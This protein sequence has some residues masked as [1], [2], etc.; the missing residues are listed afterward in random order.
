MHQDTKK[1]SLSNDDIITNMISE[2]KIEKTLFQNVDDIFSDTEG[3]SEVGLDCIDPQLL[4]KVPDGLDV[5][6]TEQDDDTNASLAKDNV[7]TLTQKFNSAGNRTGF[8]DEDRQMSP[9]VSELFNWSQLWDDPLKLSVVQLNKSDK[10]QDESELSEIED[11]V[12][13]SISRDDSL[14]LEMD[15]IRSS[16]YKILSINSRGDQVFPDSF[17]ISFSSGLDMDSPNELE[18]EEDDREAL[19]EVV[20]RNFESYGHLKNN[21][22]KV[23]P[24][25]KTISK[26]PVNSSATTE[27]SKTLDLKNIEDDIIEEID[28][29]SDVDESYS[30]SPAGN[31]PP[32]ISFTKYYTGT[33]SNPPVER[34]QR[35]ITLGSSVEELEPNR[36]TEIL[37]STTTRTNSAS[38]SSAT[39]VVP[40]TSE[41]NER[42]NLK[43]ENVKD[44]QLEMKSSFALKSGESLVIKEDD[45][46]SKT[47]GIHSISAGE[48]QPPVDVLSYNILSFSPGTSQPPTE[49]YSGT[50]LI[51]LLAND[52]GRNFP[53]TSDQE[54]TAPYADMKDK[55][56]WIK[57]LDS[58]FEIDENLTAELEGMGKLISSVESFVQTT[59][60]HMQLSA[61]NEEALPQMEDK[62]QKEQTGKDNDKSKDNK[63]VQNSSKKNK[64]TKEKVKSPLNVYQKKRNQKVQKSSSALL[65]ANE[66]PS[67]KSAASYTTMNNERIASFFNRL[68][69]RI[70]SSS[71]PALKSTSRVN[72][73]KLNDGNENTGNEN[74]DAFGELQ[75]DEQ[76]SC[77][78]LSSPGTVTAKLFEENGLETKNTLKQ[79]QP[80]FV[81]TIQSAKKI[82]KPSDIKEQE[83]KD[84]V[85]KESKEISDAKTD[86]SYWKPNN[87]FMEHRG[88]SV[89]RKATIKKIFTSRSK[90]SSSIK[91]SSEVKD[92]QPPNSAISQA[93]TTKPSW[94]RSIFRKRSKRREVSRGFSMES[95]VS[96][97][98]FAAE[99]ATKQGLQDP[100]LI[101]ALSTTETRDAKKIVETFTELDNHRNDGF[102]DISNGMPVTR[103]SM[104]SGSDDTLNSVLSEKLNPPRPL[105]EYVPTPIPRERSLSLFYKRKQLQL[106][107]QK[108]NKSLDN[109][110]HIQNQTIRFA[111]SPEVMTSR[112]RLTTSQTVQDNNLPQVE[113]NKIPELPS[114]AQT[115]KSAL[116]EQRDQVYHKKRGTRAFFKRLKTIYRK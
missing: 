10:E 78:L 24:S 79:E 93:S 39:N 85:N 88:K 69:A 101:D 58:A 20:K 16:Q 46:I 43:E 112:P 84:E 102:I 90:D 32:I 28:V 95:G 67:P 104:F 105:S 74:T 63:E 109:A 38:R 29:I 108:R 97:E 1:R 27:K 7:S 52:L 99:Y 51:N 42:L 9:T 103:D 35:F 21:S 72:S 115:Q 87:R 15:Q 83:S 98:G 80:H 111:P 100:E 40:E 19:L 71:N 49:V 94:K 56:D 76:I 86:P 55:N 25:I 13:N 41:L 62:E 64:I 107:F 50:S 6:E 59:P 34:S 37:E 89:H 14:G 57:S 23:N 3:K 44:N 116:Q 26:T 5:T 70:N 54:K 113:R 75:S 92:K 68:S 18:E 22:P 91:D 36:G 73:G 114:T 45:R 60:P 12:L 77:E 47:T 33:N 2:I 66:L 96:L 82:D 110:G 4:Q 106:T 31:I 8:T 17:H 61:H 11:E 30:S 53:S 81:E 48:N 65:P